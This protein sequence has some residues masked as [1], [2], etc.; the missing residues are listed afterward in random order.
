MYTNTL[1]V[2]YTNTLVV[3]YTT[4][5]HEHTHVVVVTQ[6]VTHVMI[7]SKHVTCM[8]AR[9]GQTSTQLRC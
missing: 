5:V 3:M 4:S 7:A 8:Q 6:L 9:V 1:V 2:M